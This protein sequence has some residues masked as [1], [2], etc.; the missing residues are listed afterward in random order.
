MSVYEHKQGTYKSYRVAR[1]VE[2]KLRQK[3][4]PLSEDG[5]QAAKKLDQEWADEQAT[6]QTN[7]TGYRARWRREPAKAERATESKTSSTRYLKTA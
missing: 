2:G 3:Y 1:S 4:F 7:F 5:L 6:A